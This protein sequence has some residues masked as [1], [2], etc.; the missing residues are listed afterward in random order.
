MFWLAFPTDTWHVKSKTVLTV[1][2]VI[3]I[4]CFE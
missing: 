2:N 3:C 1:F 4:T